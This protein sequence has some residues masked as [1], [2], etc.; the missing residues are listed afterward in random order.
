MNIPCVHQTFSSPPFKQRSF[1]LFVLC[2][3][4]FLLADRPWE[5]IAYL[6]GF[7]FQMIYAVFMILVAIFSGRLVIRS[8]RTNFW[9]SGLLIIHFIFAPFAFSPSLAVEQG[10]EYAKAVLVYFLMIATVDDE[11]DLKILLDAFALS[12][13]VY[14]VH[15]IWEFLNGR[16]VYRMDM[17]RMVGVGNL[18]S[19]P[20]AFGASLILSVP[21]VYALARSGGIIYWRRCLY[22]GYIFGLVPVCIILTGSRSA[23]IALLCCVIIGIFS[24]KRGK[25]LFVIMFAVFVVLGTWQFI[26]VDKRE[27]IR[28]LWDDEAGPKNA[29]ESAEGRIEGFL[30][31]ME[32]FK[33]KPFT[34]VG[35]GGENYIR[36]RVAMGYSPFQAHNLYGEVLSEFGIFGA[37]LLLGLT[38]TTWR[39]GALVKKKYRDNTFSSSFASTTAGA[40][41]LSLFLLLVI[42]LG[43]HTFYR[44]F[45]LYLAAWS[46]LL[47]K[48]AQPEPVALCI[49]GAVSSSSKILKSSEA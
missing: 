19:D 21:I 47:F 49:G 31:S 28:T 1:L 26:P 20:N 13:V 29:H 30:I 4:I 33:Q 12:M 24:L 37:L 48:L 32:M 46:S 43:G 2:G 8:A 9:V 45:W 42:G 3:Y 23:F 22:Y 39:G 10:V 40:V 6:N 17:I 7:P 11:T 27:R 38:W 44:P 15:S 34:G 16:Y 18:Y 5:S 36:Y 41:M 25:R 14:I 35:A